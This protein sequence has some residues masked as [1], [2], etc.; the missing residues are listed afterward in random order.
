MYTISTT[1]QFK[2]DVKK[3]IKQGLPMDE[4]KEVVSLLEEFGCLPEK[5]R[6]HRLKGNRTGQ[7]ECHIEP[8][9]LLI[10]EQNDLTITI[11]LV[12]TGSHSY[13]F[14]KKRR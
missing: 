1:T 11:L 14:D 13:L 10:W 8:D 2:R 9:W 3:C 4:L 5:Y 12:N 6:P 7:W